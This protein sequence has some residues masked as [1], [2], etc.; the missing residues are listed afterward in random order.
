MKKKVDESNWKEDRPYGL[1]FAWSDAYWLRLRHRELGEKTPKWHMGR[2]LEKPVYPVFI[3]EEGSDK[4]VFPEKHYVDEHH[5]FRTPRAFVQFAIEQ[6]MENH[7][8]V[9]TARALIPEQFRH[10]VKE[11]SVNDTGLTCSSR[12]SPRLPEV[13]SGRASK[14]S[15]LVP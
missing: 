2:L 13:L 8:I 12:V 4:F 1:W 3:L 10:K 7:P 5:T 15:K 11:V 6:G 14:S 9:I